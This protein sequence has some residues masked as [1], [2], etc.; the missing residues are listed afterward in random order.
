MIQKFIVIIQSTV[1][2]CLETVKKFRSLHFSN[3]TEQSPNYQR[4]DDIIGGRKKEQQLTVATVFIKR[5]WFWI[6]DAI[7]NILNFLP[8]LREG[9]FVALHPEVFD[10]NAQTPR[11]VS[12]CV[13]KKIYF[14]YY[15]KEAQMQKLLSHF[16]NIFF[17]RG[18]KIM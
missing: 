17:H 5:V 13:S 10:R 14:L 9:S 6:V 12:W 7:S 2:H 8:V 15:I 3:F 18:F 1:Q 16:Y 11:E 4:N